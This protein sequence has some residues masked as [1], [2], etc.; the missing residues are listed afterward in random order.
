[1]TP[2]II[3]KWNLTLYEDFG[4]RSES[5]QFCRRTTTHGGATTT[6]G[7]EIHFKSLLYF[8]LF[9]LYIYFYSLFFIFI[10]VLYFIY[11]IFFSFVLLL[12]CF[13]ILSLF[14][15]AF[16]L[17]AATFLPCSSHGINSSQEMHSRHPISSS[18]STP[19]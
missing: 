6:R 9:M 10:Y 8:P 11:F 13:F 12:F 14:C 3:Q 1:M 15:F 16:P 7:D 4:N 2:V 18:P 19:I 5:R 17:F